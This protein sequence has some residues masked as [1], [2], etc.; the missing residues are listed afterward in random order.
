MEAQIDYVIAIPTYR[1]AKI[2]SERT[3][4][5]LSSFDV[6][7]DKIHIFCSS[8]DDIDEYRR[9]N[10]IY[11]DRIIISPNGFLPTMQF[12]HTYFPVGTNVICMEDDTKVLWIK[13]DDKTRIAMNKDQFYQMVNRG[14]SECYK[15]GAKLWGL[16]PVANPLFMKNKIN[17][18]LKFIYGVFQAFISTHNPEVIP[19]LP[20]V[21]DIEASIKF[22]LTYGTVIRFE[23][24]GLDGS[25]YANVPGGLQATEDRIKKEN[26]C[27]R[28]LLHKY[29]DCCKQKSNCAENRFE[30]LVGDFRNDKSKP[31][32][33]VN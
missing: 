5:M 28:V 33:V 29:P 13:K 30:L 16:Y 10:P 2:L 12:L 23:N 25:G 9:L 18:D 32:R 14:F 27:K 8:N 1:R 6:P 7:P 17:R 26:E 19:S 24:I 22:F 31:F 21:H 11:A 20:L 4:T 15:T 3:L